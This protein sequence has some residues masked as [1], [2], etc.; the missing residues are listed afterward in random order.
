MNITSKMTAL[1]EQNQI[2]I[3]QL[4]YDHWMSQQKEF[5][6]VCVDPKVGDYLSNHSGGAICMYGSTGK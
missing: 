4:V 5:G 2:V 3:G 6:P 1:A